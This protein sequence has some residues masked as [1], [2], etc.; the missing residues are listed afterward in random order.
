MHLQGLQDILHPDRMRQAAILIQRPQ[1]VQKGAMGIQRTERAKAI[2]HLIQKER[3]MHLTPKVQVKARIRI[4][5]KTERTARLDSQVEALAG[6]LEVSTMTGSPVVVMM[7]TLGQKGRADLTTA[8]LVDTKIRIEGPVA[9]SRML[10]V[11]LDLMSLLEGVDLTI[12]INR[13]LAVEMMTQIDRNLV[14]ELIVLI[15]GPL[16]HM[17]TVLVI[18]PVQDLAEKASPGHLHHL[19]QPLVAQLLHHRD[20]LQ[21]VVV[22]LLLGYSR[23]LPLDRRGAVSWEAN[24]KNLNSIGSVCIIG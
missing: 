17:E 14:E 12:L 21:L 9:S 18:R 19:Q 13:L 11:S 2:L 7:T 8:R 5:A 10:L 24:G 20:H 1:R 4:K 23:D 3:D 22:L 16:L 6:I 15:M